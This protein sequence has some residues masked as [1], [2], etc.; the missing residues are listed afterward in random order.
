MNV[1][2]KH[3]F[4]L[5]RKNSNLPSYQ[6]IIEILELAT[7]ANKLLDESI[8]KKGPFLNQLSKM[9]EIPSSDI[10]KGFQILIGQDKKFLTSPHPDMLNEKIMIA[11]KDPTKIFEILKSDDKKNFQKKNIFFK[12]LRSKSELISIISPMKSLRD[13]ND[14]EY[15]RNIFCIDEKTPLEDIKKIY[16]KLAAKKH[17]DKLSSYSIPSGFESVV[18]KNF[19]IIQQAYDIIL[20]EHK[21]L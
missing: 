14:L 3:N 13:K 21:K 19:S 10:M 12:D 16:K 8:S 6:E 11:E 9:W 17:P 7:I 1:I 4:L 2:L 15:A 20:N 18:T 5:S